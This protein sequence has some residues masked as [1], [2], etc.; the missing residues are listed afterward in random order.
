MKQ[1]SGFMKMLTFAAA[2][3]WFGAAAH[4]QSFADS[5]R[6]P[7]PHNGRELLCPHSAARA[8]VSFWQKDAARARADAAALYAGKSNKRWAYVRVGSASIPTL[9]EDG[10]SL[11]H[12]QPNLADFIAYV[13][14]GGEAKKAFWSHRFNDGAFVSAGDRL[15]SEGVDDFGEIQADIRSSDFCVIQTGEGR[16]ARELKDIVLTNTIFVRDGNAPTSTDLNDFKEINERLLAS[17]PPKDARKLKDPQT[18]FVTT[19]VSS[20]GEN[21]V[22]I[23]R[24]SDA[25]AIG[26]LVG[27]LYSFKKADD[28]SLAALM[29]SLKRQ[30]KGRLYVYG[31]STPLVDFEKL[32][33]ESDIAVI[34]RGPSVVKSFLQTDNQLWMLADRRF[35]P[36][37]TVALNGIP[38]SEEELTAMN[39]PS[40]AV[41]TWKM[42]K[43]SVDEKI[44]PHVSGKILTKDDLIR[45]LQGGNNDV[46]FLFA[47][48]DGKALFFGTERVTLKELEALRSTRDGSRPRV[49]V[50]VACNAGRLSS[51]RRSFFSKSIDSLGE[52]LIRKHFF[53]KVIAPDHEIDS[54]ESLAVLTA[55][56]SDSK[57][58]RP[59]WTT[60]ADNGMPDSVWR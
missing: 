36:K 29:A 39:K 10:S 33:T 44:D 37:T 34:R 5:F 54:T 13:P 18:T 32:G 42:F 58:A 26:R 51:E 7:L 55:Y 57:A 53:E 46:L 28:A 48:F 49:A 24:G 3:L 35:D 14:R 20:K 15:V 40:S 59:G 41:D 25:A 12:A 47:H 17:L 19:A 2:L 1:H 16:S 22:T 4:A 45:E 31:A 11:D 38:G 60:L 9:K 8:T 30:T 52:L 6:S 23:F 50:L 56:L 27:E 21:F 43:S